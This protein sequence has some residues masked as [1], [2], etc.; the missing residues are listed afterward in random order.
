MKVSSSGMS[1][2]EFRKHAE[3]MSKYFDLRGC[4]T[5]ECI[6]K[7]IK[8]KNSPNLDGLIKAGFAAR[9]IIESIHNPH[10][11]ARA[12]K[13]KWHHRVWCLPSSRCPP[14]TLNQRARSGFFPSQARWGLNLTKKKL[15]ADVSATLFVS[16]FPYCRHRNC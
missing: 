7:R 6:N 9:L 5:P 13:G 11:V 12:R 10:P 1:P 14:A 3:R 2:N 4:Q 16:C 8:S 15:T